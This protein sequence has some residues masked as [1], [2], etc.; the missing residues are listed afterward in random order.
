MTNVSGNIF[1]HTITGQTIGAT[2]NYAV[3]F[4]YANGLSVT[5]YFPY[6][7]G[8]NCALGQVDYN[9]FTDFTFTNPARDFIQITSKYKIDKVEM[10]SIIGN[11]VLDT[12]VNTNT[13]DVS[14]V[15][16]GIYVLTIYSGNQKSNKKIVIQ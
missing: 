16:E 4:A 10:Y 11:K 7:V 15:A 6:V 5:E 14:N 3:K 2:I 13:I 1:T 12:Q 8:N 9:E